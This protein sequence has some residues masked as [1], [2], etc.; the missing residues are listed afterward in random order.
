MEHEREVNEI[1]DHHR[2]QMDHL[3]MA[4]ERVKDET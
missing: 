4:R 1:S 2:R 3:L